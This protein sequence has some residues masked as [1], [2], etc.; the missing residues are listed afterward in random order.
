VAD[1]ISHTTDIFEPSDS[2][3]PCYGKEWVAYKDEK[4]FKLIEENVERDK[5]EENCNKGFF[6]ND[7]FIP[8][9]VSIKSAAEQQFLTKFVFDI[10]GA[11]ENVWIGAKRRTDNNN[12]FVW[13]DG[14]DIDYTN[15]AEGSPS[16][17][18]DCV[19]MK[20]QFSRRFSNISQFFKSAI[21]GKWGNVPCNKKNLA[22]CQKL[23]IWS[24]P[25][26]QQTLLDIRKNLTDALTEVKNELDNLKQNP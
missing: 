3:G 20:S 19:Q 9:L 12:Q 4:C 7:L 13:N 10:S 17:N 16:G 14:T 25:Q 18:G 11:V 24:V 5:A 8:T 1:Y 6:K 22:L 2:T 23:Q 21:N 15:W 26:L